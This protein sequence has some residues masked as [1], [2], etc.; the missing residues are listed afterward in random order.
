MSGQKAVQHQNNETAEI[1][2]CLVFQ[3]F[4]RVNIIDQFIDFPVKGEG[5]VDLVKVILQHIAADIK[6]VAVERNALACL[7]WD[8]QAVVLQFRAEFL[9][10]AGQSR[11]SDGHLIGQIV[12]QK[13][14]LGAH[15]LAEHVVHA[16]AGRV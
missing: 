2:L 9:E 5:A 7:A 1:C 13:R 8:L 10:I 11:P 6:F 16:V 3:M 14:H 15:E 4:F 12:D